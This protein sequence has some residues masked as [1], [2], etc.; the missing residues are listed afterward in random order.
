VI[1]VL[2]D[3]KEVWVHGAVECNDIASAGRERPVGENVVAPRRIGGDVGVGASSCM[4]L[5][6]HLIEGHVRP[7]ALHT[8]HAAMS[9]SIPREAKRMLFGFC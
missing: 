2:L 4:W 3:I 8:R 5:R 1:V 9:R 7:E 6:Q